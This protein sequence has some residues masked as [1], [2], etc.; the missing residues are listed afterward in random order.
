MYEKNGN[1][2]FNFQN[3]FPISDIMEMVFWIPRW[4]WEY[5]LPDL[6]MYHYELSIIV[7]YLNICLHICS[8][9]YEN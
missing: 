4:M 6:F 1:K 5:F 9:L 7:T 8:F 2:S 3:I